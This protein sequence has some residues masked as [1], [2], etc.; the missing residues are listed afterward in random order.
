MILIIY[1]YNINVCAAYII[2]IIYVHSIRP[3]RYVKYIE[4]WVCAASRSESVEP[5]NRRR[6]HDR[7]REVAWPGRVGCVSAADDDVDSGLAA[8][9]LPLAAGG[10][11]PICVARDCRKRLT[12]VLTAYLH[13]NNNYVM[14][15]NNNCYWV[16]GIFISLFSGGPATIIL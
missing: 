15:Y 4:Q 16:Y 12:T 7:R 2:I 11:R 14:Y 1:K 5:I 9:R 10:S 3:A 13:N 6:A 8:I